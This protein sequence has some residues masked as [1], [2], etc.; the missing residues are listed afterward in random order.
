MDMFAPREEPTVEHVE[1]AGWPDLIV[2]APATADFIGKMAGGL[3]D[4][5]PSTVLCAARGAVMLAPAMNDGM[6]AD[7]A[8]RRNVDVLA[9]DGRMI[10]GPGSGDLAC[11][12][13][14]S[15]RMAEP[16]EIFSAVE[17]FF[18]PGPL[19]GRHFVVTAGRTVEEIDPVRY[20][21]NYSSG[22]M[23]FALAEAARQAG[24]RVTLIHG[25]V[26]VQVPA[27]DRVRAVKSAREMKTAVM[28]A[29]PGCDVLIMA[30][31]V[32]DYR[33]ARRAD[34]KI[35]KDDAP[36]VVELVRNPDI[37]AAVKEK[38]SGGQI[39]VGFALETA[40]G[41]LNAMRKME[42]KGCDYMVLNMVGEETGFGTG[43][44]QVTLFGNG[45]RLATTPVI[46]K[47]EAARMIIGMLLEDK[48][49]GKAD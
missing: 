12:T 18:G 3:A 34:R 20:I 47:N 36:G 44:N 23:G 45:K 19:D 21:S 13:T 37:L 39:V 7:P 4:D 2:V 28:R 27:A 29:L 9:G 15:G 10:V 41:E 31:A 30:A 16:G 14:G 33:P 43:T 49:L 22:R 24:A 1:I 25:A 35:K 17:G 26:D 11:G 32:A 42:E 46:S 5:L 8:V 40:E 6:W 38:R 48:R